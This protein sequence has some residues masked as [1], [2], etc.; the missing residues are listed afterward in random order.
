M[1]VKLGADLARVREQVIQLLSAYGGVSGSAHG[2][3][4]GAA[5]GGGSGESPSGS[6]VLDQF[7]RNLTQLAREKALDPVIGRGRESE[8]VMQILSR[9]T[10][11]NPVLVGGAGRGQDRH[12]GGSG[13]SHRVQ[14][15]S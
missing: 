12:R 6:H 10:K 2:E 14:R 11:N 13:P 5:S 9:R 3:K 1:L 4:S 7:G 8:R 15:R